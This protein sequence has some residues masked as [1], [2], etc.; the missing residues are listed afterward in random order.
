MEF[1]V[2]RKLEGKVQYIHIPYIYYTYIHENAF[3][4][5]PGVADRVDPFRD[6][7]KINHDIIRP[8]RL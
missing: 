1:E 5:A 3:G 6:A 4:G 7:A 8:V 2:S